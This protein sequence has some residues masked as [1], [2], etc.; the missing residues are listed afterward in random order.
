MKIRYKKN[1]EKV[2]MFKAMALVWQD[3]IVIDIKYAG[4]EYGEKILE[5]ERK[6]FD[7]IT[8]LFKHTSRLNWLRTLVMNNVWDMLSNFKI[9]LLYG[10]TADRFAAL[11]TLG[12]LVFFLTLILNTMV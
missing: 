2:M 7:Y 12:F 4:T 1:L 5:H 8:P 6:H 3:E 11:S 9:S 10:D